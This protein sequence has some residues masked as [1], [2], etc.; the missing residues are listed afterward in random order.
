M[1]VVQYDV[2]ELVGDKIA[3]FRQTLQRIIC[4]SSKKL[5]CLVL[6]TVTAS[7]LIHLNHAFSSVVQ[8]YCTLL[9]VCFIRYLSDVFH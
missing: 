2:G 6:T 1:D 7:I 9:S 4:M 8:L 5:T 3:N